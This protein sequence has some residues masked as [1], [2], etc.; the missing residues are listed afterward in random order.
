MWWYLYISSSSWEVCIFSCSWD[1]VPSCTDRHTATISGG[2]VL[3][4]MTAICDIVLVPSLFIKAVTWEW[5]WI[6]CLFVSRGSGGPSL[7]PSKW[8]LLHKHHR[9]M[10]KRKHHHEG[11]VNLH[12]YS[13]V[14]S[15][16]DGGVANSME[17]LEQF[18]CRAKTWTVPTHFF[19]Y[20]REHRELVW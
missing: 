19:A 12:C 6:P 15:R 13:P 20:V 14:L 2:A 17:K 16:D 18:S 7:N 3:P 5:S 4:Y 1:G 8:S 9:S 11:K 10:H